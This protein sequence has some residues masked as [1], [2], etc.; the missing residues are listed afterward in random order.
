MSD[1]I[2]YHYFSG[3][4]YN[5][6]DILNER[7]TFNHIDSFNDP[8]EL[9][10]LSNKESSSPKYDGIK[11]KHTFFFRVFCF[12]NGFLNSNMWGHYTNSHKGFCVGYDFDNIVSIPEFKDRL[13]FDQIKYGSEPELSDEDIDCGAALYYKSIDWEK[14]NEFRASIR[15][16]DEELKIINEI[17]FNSAR[18]SWSDSSDDLERVVDSNLKWP[19][20]GTPEF[21]RAHAKKFREST[22]PSFILNRTEAHGKNG[23]D[24]YEYCLLKDTYGKTVYGGYPLRVSGSLKAK[25][26]YIGLRTPD[27]TRIKLKEYARKN[28]IDIYDIKIQSGNYSLSAQKIELC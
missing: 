23:L 1:K 16:D 8:T 19:G 9:L 22:S 21:E 13:C 4:D 27:A 6:D 28:G 20:H 11:Y 15:L 17:E 26:I 24:G 2:F 12:S 7:I 5:I 10:F 25:V 14:E 3:S 18:K